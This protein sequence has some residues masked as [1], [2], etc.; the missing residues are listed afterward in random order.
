MAE[1]LTASRLV[2]ALRAEG[3]KVVEVANWQTNNRNRVGTWG[4]VH[5][6][7]LHHTVTP[8][9]MNAVSM[10]FNGTGKLPGPLCHGVI[11]RDG[12]VHMVGNGRANHAGGGDPDVLAAVKAESYNTRPPATNEHQGSDGA[13]DGNRAFY[14]WECENLGDGKDPWPRVQVEAMVRVSAALARAHGWTAKSI[15]GHLEWS[16]WKSDPKG[17][18]NVVSMPGLR[19]RIAERLLHPASWT[20]GTTPKPPTPAPTGG[21]VNLTHLTR[22]TSTPLLPGSPVRIYWEN[23][24]ADEPNQHGAGGY[25]VLSQADWTANLHLF[26]SGLGPDE[27]LQV[28]HIE[29]PPGGDP[30]EGPLVNIDGFKNGGS[31][32]RVVTLIGR[33]QNSETLSFE[34]TNLGAGTVTLHGA[35]LMMHS[36]PL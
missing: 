19:T 13:V 2:A 26:F 27:A 16:D 15:I 7:M 29:T 17:P 24:Y 25:S 36:T 10:C 20:P 32:T 21:T 18:D 12:T 8:K 33:I 35:R 5:G 23:E 9:T 6:S 30:Q 11:R 4:P 31:V 3:V 28:R 22:T 1:P 14:G 34:V